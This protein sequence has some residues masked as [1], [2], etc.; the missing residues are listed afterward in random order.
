MF[1]FCLV[2]A[3]VEVPGF[4][5]DKIINTLNNKTLMNKLF[6]NDSSKSLKILKF[7]GGPDLLLVD[8]IV[9]H[10]RNYTD[11]NNILILILLIRDTLRLLINH[12][13]WYSYKICN[14]IQF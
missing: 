2:K 11:G 10:I 6:P 1:F 9:R 3:K 8:A 14:K 4:N 12:A 13:I 5:T 7:I